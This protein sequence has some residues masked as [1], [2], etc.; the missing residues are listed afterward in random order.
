[1]KLPDLFK[2]TFF[3]IALLVM[4]GCSCFKSD[5]QEIDS[6]EQA[7]DEFSKANNTTLIVF[8]MDDTLLSPTEK[9]FYLGYKDINDFD[10]SDRN[11]VTE[12]RRDIKKLCATHDPK[13]Y[14]KKLNSSIWIK[15]HYRPMEATTVSTVKQLQA[16][17]AK[18]IALTS[19]NTGRYGII[20]NMQQYR[21]GNLHEVGL[22]FSSSFAIAEISFQQLANQDENPPVFYRGVLC[23]DGST[24]GKT[25]AAFLD[26]VGFKPTK[27][28]FFDDLYHNCK[29][30]VDEMKQRGLDIQCYHYRAA[31]KEKI[32]LN[33]AAAMFQFDYWVKHEEFLSEEE[34]LTMLARQQVQSTNSALA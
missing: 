16:Q 3:L 7:Q 32:K 9:M 10:P 12:L 4:P 15:N 11:L 2:H 31:Y 29:S 8:D 25:L 21:F 33:Q 6:L 1:M 5:I 14:Y 27:I 22:D 18:V 24:K 17:G 13:A 28:L 19:S 30:V 23:S 34:A 26:A 20:E